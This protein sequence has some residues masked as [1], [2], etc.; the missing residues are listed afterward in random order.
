MYTGYNNDNHRTTHLAYP[1]MQDRP[2]NDNG[3]SFGSAHA[4]AMNMAL[5]DASVRQVSYAVDKE[6][7]RRLGHREDGMPVDLSHL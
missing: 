2:G 7:H 3:S 1:P 6:L 4:G 5:S